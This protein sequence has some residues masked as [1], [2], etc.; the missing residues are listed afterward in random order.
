MIEIFSTCPPSTN[1]ARGRYLECV[2]D[3][4]RWSERAG[5][6]GILVHSDNSLVDP[7]MLSHVIVQ[8]TT[9][10]SPVVA[11]RP[12]YMQP[13]WVAKQVTTF[14]YLYGRRLILNMVAEGFKNDLEALNDTTPHDLR[15]AR[16]LEYTAMV[17]RLLANG[18]PLTFDG[19]FYKS[20]NLKLTPPLSKALLPDVFVSDSSDAGVD[21]ARAIGATAIGCPAPAGGKEQPAARTARLGLRV[22]IV[23]RDRG[24]HAWM[25]ARSRFPDDH[26]GGERT[27]ENPYW[28]VPLES[29][30]TMCPYLVGS[31]D[32][33]AHELRR[34]IALGYETFIVD[35]PPDPEEL[36]HITTAFTLAQLAV[37]V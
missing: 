27:R 18:G 19:A 2:A 35:V 30:Q 7:W 5:C 13:Y 14:G 12:V 8:N 33:V 15:L 34:Y 20:V 24:D 25:I 26:R 37:A 4:A 17:M 21:A 1:I 3:V 11:V 10:L 31:Y 16:L 36:E 6:T 9:T 28:L 29:Y 32:T 22:G 23:T